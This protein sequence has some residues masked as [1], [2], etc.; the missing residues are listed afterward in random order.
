MPKETCQVWWSSATCKACNLVVAARGRALR[1]RRRAATTGRLSNEHTLPRQH[2]DLP[3]RGRAPMQSAGP[4]RLGN[5]LP[6]KLGSHLERVIPGRAQRLFRAEKPSAARAQVF[7]HNDADHLEAV[8]RAS[9]A[10]G[11]PRTRRPWRKVLVVVE[12][13]YSMEGEVVDLAGIV[14]VAKKYKA[15]PGAARPRQSRSFRRSSWPELWRSRRSRRR[16]LVQRG[17]ARRARHGARRP[18]GGVGR[19]VPGISRGGTRAASGQVPLSVQ[20][21]AIPQPARAWRG[22]S[23]PPGGMDGL[24]AVGGGCGRVGRLIDHA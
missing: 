18:L 15:R 10:E 1:W 7:A 2:S 3:R 22:S 5:G 9:I 20:R 16:V 21:A 19:G 4:R 14:A 13:I 6:L 8:L 24:L 17:C 23:T 11:Q 12:G